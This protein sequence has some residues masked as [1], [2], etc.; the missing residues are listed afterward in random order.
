[1]TINVAV[2]IKQVPNTN[3]VKIDKKTG[4]L[5]RKGIASICNP[6]DKNALE[7]ALKLKDNN[8]DVK[9]TVL[10]M[11][12]SQAAIVLKEALAMG[13]DRG[14]LL[15]DRKFAGSDTLATSTILA[16]ALRKIGEQEKKNKKNG[17]DI[18]FCG[19]QAI[20]GDTAQ[21]GPQIA[22]HLDLPIVSYV[23]EFEYLR[24]KIIA[25][26]ALENGYMKIESRIPVVI[27]T[28]NNLNTPRYPHIGRIFD[29]YGKNPKIQIET[30]T[31]EDLPDLDQT[32][33]GL[34]G[35]PTRVRRIFTPDRTF[36]GEILKG[37]PIH[38]AKLLV[39]R[40]KQK[41]II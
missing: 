5:I 13:A 35:S 38:I 24:N 39:D 9:I 16:A 28:I 30:W 18:I 6:D 26:R 27:T 40:L 37:D 10:S 34:S 15:S 23:Q 22:Q 12:P 1:M 7:E 3:R 11:G 25:K 41:Q 21:V 32:Q 19:N 4:T 20:D 29:V 36:H 17:L 33:I 14:I 31:A 2:C 8:E